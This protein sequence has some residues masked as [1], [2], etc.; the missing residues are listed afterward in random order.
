MLYRI[1][2]ARKRRSLSVLYQGSCLRGALLATP[3]EFDGLAFDRETMAIGAGDKPGAEIVIMHFL[4][5]TAAAADQQLKAVLMF[6]AV[7]GKV[8]IE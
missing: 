2:S 5:T 7:A 8:G 1:K 3:L 6:R 4:D